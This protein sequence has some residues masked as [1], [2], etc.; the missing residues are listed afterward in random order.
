MSRR[1]PS[2]LSERPD[3]SS[4]GSLRAIPVVASL[5]LAVACGTPLPSGSQSDSPEA[6][7]IAASIPDPLPNGSA[8]IQASDLE[9]LVVLTGGTLSIGSREGTLVDIH[10]PAAMGFSATRGKL[11]VQ[12]AGPALAAVD[13]DLA[14]TP[15]LSW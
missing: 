4:V 8:D 13:V 1:P 2:A 7:S 14:D 9:G 3:R 10:G 6:A 11:I 12:T 15:P 5:F